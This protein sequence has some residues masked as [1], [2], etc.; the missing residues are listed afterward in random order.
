VTVPLFG[1]QVPVLDDPRADPQKGTGVVMCCTFGDTTDKEW[2]FTHRLPLVE[3]ISGDGRMTAAAGEFA[4]LEIEQARQKAVSALEERGLLLDRQPIMQTVRVHERCD[5]PVEYLMSQQWFIRVLDQKEALL[6]AGESLRWIPEHMGARYHS[7]VENL[8]WD[9][10]ISR[11]RYFGVPFPL[12][13]CQACGEMILAGEEQL[14]VDPTDTPPPGPCTC[15]STEFIPEADVMDTWATSSM[16]PQIVGGWP[17][18]EEP[19][20]ENLYKSVFPFSLRPQ[21]HEIIRT[22][23]FY[24]IVKSLFHFGAI[25]WKDVSISGWGIAGEGMGKISKSRGGGPLPP[26]EMI[27]R[28]SADAVRYWAASTGLGKNAVI[29]EEKI[30]TGA[31][32]VTKIWNSARFSE[33]FLAGYH[34]R[35]APEAAAGD[36]MGHPSAGLPG[37]T[38]ADRWILSR[39]QRLVRRVTGLL[40]D[41]DHAAAKSEIENFFWNDFADNYLEMCKQ[42]LYAED[43]PQRQQAC[44]TLYH[45]LLTTIQ[46]L[47]PF[48]PYVT[49]EIYQGLFADQEGAS[50]DRHNSI[51]RSRWPVPDERLEDEAAERAG[52]ALVAIATVVRRYKSERSLPLSSELEGLELA[53]QDENL[54]EQL[55]EA[56]SDLLSVTRARKIEVVSGFRPGRNVIQAGINVRL[57][58]LSSIESDLE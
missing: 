34:P 37:F 44:F 7:W 45:V 58:I 54:A 19:S 38:P 33:K 51:H 28:Y 24:T 36:K 1:Q 52:E 17:A 29:S 50:A 11:Q 48:L 20:S 12:W 15:G 3:A 32:F 5:T 35:V 21:G 31:R 14:P 25:P 30:Q 41:Y 10:C 42:R 4:G 46:L 39:N 47:A 56:S 8:A 26:L 49:E 18:G 53:A 13:Y 40:E 23:A 27:E 16:T 55:L 22:W 57:A 9:W 2:W 43:H 6:E